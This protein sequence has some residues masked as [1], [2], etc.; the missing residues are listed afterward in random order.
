ML[1]VVA[2]K[3]LGKSPQN[4][5]S[6]QIKGKHL[7][8]KFASSKEPRQK[9]VEQQ[10]KRALVQLDRVN[11]DPIRPVLFREMHRPRQVCRAAVAAAGHKTTD[12]SKRVPERNARRNHIRQSPER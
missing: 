7:P 6:K 4:G 10:I 11:A 2:A 12:A 9:R 5:V 1:R 3:T 8:I